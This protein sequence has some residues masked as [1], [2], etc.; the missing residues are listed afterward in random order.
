M[1]YEVR[2]GFWEPILMGAT[3]Q[4][5]LWDFLKSPKGVLRQ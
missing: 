2:C 4:D 5:L 3:P 1:Q